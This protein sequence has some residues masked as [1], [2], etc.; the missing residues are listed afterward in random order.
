MA[1]KSWESIRRHLVG[2]LMVSAVTG[3][4]V[5]V[6]SWQA[7]MTLFASLLMGGG[8]FCLNYAIMVFFLT[9]QSEARPDVFPV[10]FRHGF[11]FGFAGVSM[12]AAPTVVLLM[13]W[14][15]V[16]RM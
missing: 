8:A 13:G 11:L 3:L 5:A 6:V 12:M 7:D 16:F 2:Y 1:E 4:F 9:I 14:G 15:P 10:L